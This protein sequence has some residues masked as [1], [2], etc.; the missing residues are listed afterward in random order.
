MITS[1]VETNP[2]EILLFQDENSL[3]GV[4]GT[5]SR[6]EMPL[7]IMTQTGLISHLLI[8]SSPRVSLT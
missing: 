2:N 6:T 3:S 5:L 7:V 8:I 1:Q 4:I